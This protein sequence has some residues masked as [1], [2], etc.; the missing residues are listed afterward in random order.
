MN[1]DFRR[2]GGKE[3]RIREGYD[4]W[5]HDHPFNSPG[6]LHPMINAWLKRNAKAAECVRTA[7]NNLE[8]HRLA[9]ILYSLF[10][11]QEY[12]GGNAILW[13]T[14]DES[15]GERAI[16]SIA[17]LFVSGDIRFSS[18]VGELLF[19]RIGRSIGL[20]LHDLGQEELGLSLLRM[21]V[22]TTSRLEYG[23]QS[24]R[25]EWEEFKRQ[26]GRLPEHFDEV[27]KAIE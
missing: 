1:S 9:Y 21:A 19:V 20:H 24:T 18:K 23:K 25:R 4:K 5:E 11:G 2:P 3:L 13:A 22:E 10:H 12:D 6:A 17:S 15:L 26:A 27:M 16:Q 14:Q 7:R 8:R